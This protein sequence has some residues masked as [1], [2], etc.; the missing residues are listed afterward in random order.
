MIPRVDLLLNLDKRTLWKKYCG[1]LDLS[2]EEFMAIQGQLLLEQIELASSSPLAKKI[3]GERKP[4]SIEEFRDIVPITTY[5][6]YLPYLE[7]KREDLLSEK[8]F[9][10]VHTS[11]MDGYFK[12]VPYT[13]RGYY[14]L[15]D[16]LV[17]ALILASA[18]RKGEV[19][20][21]KGSLIMFHLPTRPYLG[22]HIA[23][24]LSQRIECQA[25]PPLEIFD[26]ISYE[27][28]VE[29]ELELIKK[30]GV[31]FIFS[32]PSNIADMG[33]K[34]TEQLNCRGSKLCSMSSPIRSLQLALTKL[35][36]RIKDKPILPRHLCQ[37]QGI[38]SIGTDSHFY[39]EEI[40]YYWGKKP[41]DI[42][43]TAE[44]GCLALPGWSGDAMTFT[45]FSG[46]LEFI[47]EEEWIGKEEIRSERPDTI[48]LDELEVG[49]R[50]QIVV[51]NFYGMPFLRY[52]P[53]D[54]IK[55]TAP[56]DKQAGI[57]LPQMLYDSRIS[58][59]I[60]IGGSLAINEKKIW[61]ALLNSGL[62]Y[63]DWFLMKE[64]Y[65]KEYILHLY[66]ELKN[67]LGTEVDRLIYKSKAPIEV[68]VNGLTHMSDIPL[69]MTILP[70][71]TFQS[72]RK[73]K[74]AAGFDPACFKTLHINPRDDLLREIISS[75]GAS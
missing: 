59:I 30:H 23:F 4:S 13:S 31:D 7:E 48:L 3:I 50:Y 51:T 63:E 11:G 42:Y 72:Y 58:D 64:E 24:G 54:I 43:L 57:S 1:F 40:D 9:C 37:T 55:I 17:S 15:I 6:D 66:V 33:A 35:S 12:W 32:L 14:R 19:N 21:K 61:Q 73:E 10:W 71:G 36:N 52:R 68:E 60:N 22:G 62:K 2:V 75:N 20:I 8:P 26:R 56:N 74:E 44:T 27:D 5:K 34:F 16:S 28:K 49:K 70:R 46:F 18:N 25:I 53:G 67:G 39:R 45:P 41:Y 29:K 47:P 65:N 69:K 38:I